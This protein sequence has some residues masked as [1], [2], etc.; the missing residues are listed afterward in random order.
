MVEFQLPLLA[1]SERFEHLICD[2]FNKL[3]NENS[4]T[5][6]ID[7]QRFGVKGQEQKGIDIVSQKA[8][9][10]IQC[11][12]KGLKGNDN[13]VRNKLLID[14]NNDLAKVENL[15][16][17]FNRLI[18]ASTF[19]DD[20]HIQEFLNVIKQERNYSFNIYYWGWDT[21]T[22][23]IEQ[24]EEILRKY[25]R[26]FGKTKQPKPSIPDGAIGNDLMKKNYIHRLIKRYGDFKQEELNK[27]GEKFNWAAFNKH[28][29]NRYKATG[30]NHI[31]IT[32]FEEL[33]SYLQ[34]RIDKTIMGKAQKS[35]GYRSYKS[36]EDFLKENQ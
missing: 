12:V 23:N 4:Y 34:D 32:R 1:N 18:F 21:I 29:S 36:F 3:E 35:K 8:G 17:Q 28:I 6:N 10:I 19:R 14:I 7:F 9:T 11:K 24:Q 26:Q 16:F 31:P 15:G 22:K 33:I 20:T 5:N 27:I 25:F 30:I 13:T 2:L